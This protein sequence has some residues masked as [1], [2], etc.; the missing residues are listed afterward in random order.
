MRLTTHPIEQGLHLLAGK[1]LHLA[2]RLGWRVNEGGH[3]AYHLVL[4][5]GVSERGP[6]GGVGVAHRADR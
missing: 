6:Q 1:R 3:V 2:L 4:T 5:L